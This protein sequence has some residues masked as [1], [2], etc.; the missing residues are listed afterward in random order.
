MRKAQVNILGVSVT[1]TNLSEATARIMQWISAK[2]Q[3]Y[4][5]VTGVHGIMESQRQPDLKAVH[6]AAG[7]VTPDGMPLV[8]ISR[9]AG[10]PSSGRVYGPDLMLEGWPAA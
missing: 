9:A 7:M 4:V 3:T 1:A 10:H 2:K 6:N 8:Y 5:C